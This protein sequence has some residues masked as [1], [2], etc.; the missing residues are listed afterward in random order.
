L[1]RT[2]LLCVPCSAHVILVYLIT[3]LVFVEEEYKLSRPSLCK[4]PS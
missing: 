3:L 4:F 1:V 2:S